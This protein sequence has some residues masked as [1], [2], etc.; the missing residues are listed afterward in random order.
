[1]RNG[2]SGVRGGGDRVDALGERGAADA[3]EARL[4][5]DHLDDRE[6]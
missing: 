5:G 1:M 2:L 3:V 6:P 4:G